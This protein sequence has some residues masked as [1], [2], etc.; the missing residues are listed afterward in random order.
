MSDGSDSGESEVKGKSERPKAAG[1][2]HSDGGFYDAGSGSD[3]GSKLV[4]QDRTSVMSGYISTG[5][6]NSSDS[7][8][9]TPPPTNQTPVTDSKIKAPHRGILKSRPHQLSFQI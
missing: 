9:S 1:S 2:P 7:G 6:G 5:S 8:V 3:S 4:D